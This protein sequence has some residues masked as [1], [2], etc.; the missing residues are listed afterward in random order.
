MITIVAALIAI[1]VSFVMT[2]V[3]SRRVFG[4]A[5]RRSFIGLLGLMLISIG[6]LIYGLLPYLALAHWQLGILSN[7]FLGSVLIGM[8]LG[9]TSLYWSVRL[10]TRKKTEISAAESRLEN[11]ERR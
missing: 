2:I 7:C 9:I 8:I 1:V 3:T 4:P 5:W 10:D 11:I 6:F